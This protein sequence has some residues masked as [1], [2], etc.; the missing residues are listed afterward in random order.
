MSKLNRRDYDELDR[1]LS[2]VESAETNGRV[3]SHAILIATLA[4]LGHVVWSVEEAIRKAF[5]LLGKGWSN[6]E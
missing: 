2:E 1:A 6:D 4:K 3:G 5:E